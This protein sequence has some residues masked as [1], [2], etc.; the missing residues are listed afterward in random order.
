[1]SFWDW[2]YRYFE[3][4]GKKILEVYPNIADEIR[5]SGIHLYPEVYASFIAF[6]TIL[7]IF[8]TILISI[9]MGVLGYYLVI[10]VLIPLPFLGFI[11][12]VYLPALV[13]SSRAGG[14]EGEFPYT[15]A[16]LSMMVMSGLSPYVAFERITRS[17]RVFTK[18]AELSQRF[19]LLVR[20]L[21]RDPLT[22]FSMLAQRTPSA[23]VRD[24]LMGYVTTVRAGGDVADYLTK[25]AR[26]LFS[27]ILVKMKII[28][29]KLSGLLEAYLA[30][31]LLSMISLTVM[32][33]VTVAFVSAVPFG[34]SPFGLFLI[35]Y[36]MI[37]F[38]SG[39]I[40]YMADLTQYK[41]PWVDYR[42]YIV[43]G[44]ITI[45]FTSYLV[46]FGIVLY[47]TLPPYNPLR[48][49]FLVSGLHDFLV[50]PK[51]FS[52]IP[53][54]IEPSIAFAFALVLATIPATI[55][56][57]YLGRE[58]KVVRGITRFLR[59]LVEIRKTGLSPERSIIELS[60]RNYGVFTKYLKKMALQLS[61][62]IPL[63][64]IID[65][66]FKKIIVWRAKVLLFVMTD[67]IE[68][69]GGTVEVMEN[70]AWFAESIDAIDDEHA[71]S[72]RILLIV[73]YMGAILSAATVIMLTVFLGSLPMSIGA[74]EAAAAVTL[75]SIVLNTYLMGL[76][77]GK[78]SSGSLA[79]G[80]KHA[81][82]LTTITLLF[83][84][85]SQFMEA[86]L[87][88]LTMK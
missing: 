64:K 83:L 31:V 69:G 74:Y 70:L 75:P 55:Y 51:T 47:Y 46:V 23:T 4:P 3:R 44:G 72:L 62:G 54:Y 26:L 79:A 67:T 73:P 17:R 66:L 50:F 59:D 7:L 49:S 84:L 77:A 65:D 81:L 20:V 15:V 45:P 53:S 86:V 32:Y 61:L 34:M 21:G 57:E 13:G 11:F 48:N 58:Y 6:S 37:P 8:V 63:S 39:I 24:L 22:A 41:E 56:A 33:F 38:L 68:V 27:E 14:I 85:S 18:S 2:V 60:R 71:R 87:G 35:L 9:I 52:Q 10:P 25:K 36:I 1:M 43:F 16:Y 80:F 29:D 42:P 82:L 40:I 12:L 5:K 28:A 76:V 88:G 78:V 19:I 30:L